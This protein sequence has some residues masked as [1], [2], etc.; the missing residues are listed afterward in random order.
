MEETDA[1]E[2]G[3]SS[4]R[5]R[6]AHALAVT[7]GQLSP[8]GRDEV[9]EP[10]VVLAQADVVRMAER[11]AVRF[12]S[13]RPVDVDHAGRH[14]V[15]ALR[16]W[17]PASHVRTQALAGGSPAFSTRVGPGLVPGVSQLK[18]GGKMADP[19]KLTT[20]DSHCHIDMHEDA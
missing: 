6:T 1:G 8:A 2:G 3:D 16:M 14:P 18:L 5:R 15:H 10:R 9:G 11:Q 19:A 7:Q 4:L 12:G 13:G 20:I 17:T